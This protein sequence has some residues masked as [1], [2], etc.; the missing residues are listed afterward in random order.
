[1]EA[2]RRGFM[3]VEGRVRR[4]WRDGQRVLLSFVER[5]GGFSAEIPFDAQDDFSAGGIEPPALAGKLVRV[6]GEVSPSA[7]GPR[8][9]LDHPEQVEL[10]AER[11]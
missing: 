1:V 8:L 6:R 2:G 5:P 10:L 3:V 9:W 4:V 11:R 7:D